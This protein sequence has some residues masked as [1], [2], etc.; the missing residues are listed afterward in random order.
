[1]ATTIPPFRNEPATDFSDPDARAQFQAALDR[2]RDRLGQSYPLQIGGRAVSGP[3]TFD[4]VNPAH[5]DQVVGRHVAATVED[6]DRAVRAAEE[7]FPAWSAVPAERRAE[8]LFRAADLIRRRRHDLSA[9]MV[10]E[11]GKS[12][13]E[14]DG[15]TAEAVDLMEWYARQML[16][17]AE[18]QQLTP[19]EG[20]ETAFYYVPLGVGAIISPWNFPLALTTGMMTAALVAGNTV[21]VKP[22]SVSA[23]TV[24]WLID[25][26]LEAGR[27]VDLPDGA[28][29][30][31]T[32][33]GGRVG[34]A[35]VDHPRVRFIAFTGSKEV[36]IRINERGARVQ[37]GQIWIKRIQLEMGG[38]NG[39]VVDETADL[40]AA[41]EGIAISAFGFQGQKCSAG[42]RAIL[43]DPVYEPVLQ[44]VVERA[45]AL[46]VGDTTDPQNEIGPVVDANAERKILDYIEVGK[47]EG[48]LML[49]GEK[50]GDEG[51]FIA[52]TIFADVD[53]KARIA[54][55][56]IFGPVLSVI[57]ARDFEDALA[58]ANGT[59]FGLT[60]SLY[61][62]DEQ[63]LERAKR[64]FHVG[65]LY[66]NRKSTGALMGVHPFGGFNLSGTDSKAGGPDYLLFFLQGKSLGR[67]LE[68][69]PPSEPQEGGE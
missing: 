62:R 53:P 65:N 8:L 59:E 38:K 4:S 51:Y 3:E 30:Y 41:A 29:N 67:R 6:V 32:G 45:R 26:L 61:S 22:S 43:V 35:L 40:E 69:A 56:E 19:L 44:K 17:L 63:R 13:D 50:V 25:L 36:G 58:I 33:P 49:G 1:M 15:E 14:A 68:Q 16:R 66:F 20:E 31:L 60:G 12:W 5:P 39:V 10:Y 27:E 48:E 21:V 57:R 55:E 2:V 47:G 7:A 24:A 18:P 28:I 37:P 34:D 54:Q 52:P 46:R 42:S 11:V 9:L 64:E 23:T